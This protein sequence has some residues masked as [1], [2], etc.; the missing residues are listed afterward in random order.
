[1]DKQRVIDYIG[2]IRLYCDKLE[3][4]LNKPDAVVDKPVDCVGVYKE[5]DLKTTR[6]LIM[7]CE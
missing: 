4:E 2:V 7:C 5:I 3:K 1:M 6:P